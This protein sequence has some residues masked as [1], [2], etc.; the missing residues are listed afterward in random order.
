[1]LQN[2]SLIVKIGVDTEK[3]EPWKSDVS[4]PIS[5]RPVD[6]GSPAELVE[7]Q[8]AEAAGAYWSRQ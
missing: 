7:A 1:M 8:G 6:E 2:A 4:W 5:H 3:N